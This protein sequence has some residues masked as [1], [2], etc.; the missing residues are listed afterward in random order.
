MWKYVVK[1]LLLL[2]PV[3]LAVS[4]II[5]GIFEI[6]PGNVALMRLGEQASV[7]E[8]A[9][10]NEQLGLNKPFLYRYA[11]YI[12]N[13]VVHQ[14]MGES[15]VWGKPVWNEIANRL[16]VTLKVACNG[17]IVAVLIGVPLGI[18]SA[19]KQYSALDKIAT[20]TSLF[21]AAV[22][23]FWLAL[24]LIL[25]FAVKL[26]LFPTS[27]NGS[28]RNFVLPALSLGFPYAAQEMRYT[29]SSM[30]ETIRQDYIDT[31][32]AKGAPGRVAI[33]KHALKNAL[34]PIITITGNNVGQL[35]GGAVV[36][37]T[38]YGLPG[39]GSLMVTAISNR[40]T[41]LLCGCVIVV[42]VLYSLIMLVVDLLYAFIDPRIKAR[43]ATRG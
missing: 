30:L 38:V 29:R 25:I 3:V 28:W 24:M 42:A 26:R 10:M 12:Y 35:I 23:S 22:P 32:R 21:L 13:I 4:L 15:Y 18:Y 11:H 8:I 2:I 36:T 6:A 9:A 1:R 19:V 5:F 14:N 43:Y 20:S 40:D 17:I 31:V 7:E 16:P 34:L 41:N 27:G 39:L 33:N 37:E